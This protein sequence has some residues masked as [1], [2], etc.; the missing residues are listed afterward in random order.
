MVVHLSDSFCLTQP[1]L[2]ISNLLLT[3]RAMLQMDLPHI[4]VLTKIDK[5]AS[6]DPLPFNLD[7]YTE[8]Q[9]L[10]YLQPYLEEESPV[11]RSEKFGRLNQAI[12]DLVENFA[13]V[14]YEVLAVENKKS[15]MHLLRVID[16]AGGYVFGGAEG[17]NDT[18]WQIAMRN[19][20]SMMDVHDIQE[21]WVDAKEEYDA[22]E[23]KEW[24][25]QVE[26][27]A[28][29]EGAATPD[30]IPD[31]DDE[32]DGLPPPPTQDSGVRVVRRKQ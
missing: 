30:L 24:E 31:D 20:S 26:R 16:R 10:G 25:E 5:V 2:Y 29:G 22:A 23:Q 12:A 4:N 28:G 6:Y 17:A 15:V 19:E 9:D 32:F 27:Q 14:R 13:L 18:V 3:L 7:F 21:R 1:S 8:V 11:L